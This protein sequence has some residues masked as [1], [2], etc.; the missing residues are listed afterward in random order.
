MFRRR[1]PTSVHAYKLLVEYNYTMPSKSRVL[2]PIS[3]EGVMSYALDFP[4]NNIGS[5]ENVCHFVEYAL[6]DYMPYMGVDCRF[7]KTIAV[8]PNSFLGGSA[9]RL[10]SLPL[11]D[12][13]F[14]G[15]PKLLL[16]TTHL[17]DL[18][19]D[20]IPYSGYISPDGMVAA[21]STLTSL[22]GLV[23]GSKSPRSCPDQA[24]RRR[25][26]TSSSLDTLC[27]PRSPIFSLQWDQ[28]IFGRPRGLHR[29]PSTQQIG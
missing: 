28:R 23:L 2:C 9:P 8:V 18:Y 17:V 20:N 14:P 7:N 1:L 25:S 13:S 22:E 27:P 4:T 19:L 24:S 15:L 29:C 12:T 16:S 5:H 21:L 6:S 10:E 11:K 3:F 26:R